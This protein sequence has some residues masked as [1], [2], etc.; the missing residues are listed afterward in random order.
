MNCKREIASSSNIASNLK[1]RYSE[2]CAMHR[3]AKELHDRIVAAHFIPIYSAIPEHQTPASSSSKDLVEQ[4]YSQMRH[5]EKQLDNLPRTQTM[6][7]SEI[8]DL[9]DELK[10]LNIAAKQIKKDDANEVYHQVRASLLLFR[11][12]EQA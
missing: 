11:T 4:L 1:S 5:A 8:N 3:A 12:P 6:L 9:E 10:E 7:S 2:I